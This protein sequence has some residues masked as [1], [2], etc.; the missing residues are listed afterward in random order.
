MNCGLVAQIILGHGVLFS[1]LSIHRKED[2]HLVKDQ[3]AAWMH[4]FECLKPWGHGVRSPEASVRTALVIPCRQ[5]VSGPR[6]QRK[7]TGTGSIAQFMEQIQVAFGFHG[8]HVTGVSLMVAES[9][10]LIMPWLRD[11]HGT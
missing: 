6:V 8:V 1:W 10:L 7:K 3:P 11:P 9:F 2:N 5:P 4:P